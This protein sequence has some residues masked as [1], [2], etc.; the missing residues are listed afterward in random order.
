[1]LAWTSHFPPPRDYRNDAIILHV[2]TL[3]ICETSIGSI[4]TVTEFIFE[5]GSFNII[6]DQIIT[7]VCNNVK[8]EGL[9]SR[10]KLNFSDLFFF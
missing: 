8:R 9:Y 7:R 3:S 2:P 5:D 6:F 1:M 4:N 10:R